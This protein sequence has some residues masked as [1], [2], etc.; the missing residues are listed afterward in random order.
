MSPAVKTPGT[1]VIPRCQ[2]DDRHLAL[3]PQAL[4]DLEPVELRQHHV[5]DDQVDVLGLELPESLLAV[6]GL[7]DAKALAFQ[8]V[9]EKLLNGVLVVNEE[10]G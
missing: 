4:A 5:Q 2:H 9:C 7:Q 3:G 1:L 8:R 10:D 6:P